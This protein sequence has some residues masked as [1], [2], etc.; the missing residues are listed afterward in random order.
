MLIKYKPKQTCCKFSNKGARHGSKD[1]IGYRAFLAF[2]CFYRIKIRP[3]LTEIWTE[4]LFFHPGSPPKKKQ[5]LPLLG[6]HLY[7]RIYGISAMQ[8]RL[9]LGD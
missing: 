2:R 9:L 5:G 6:R 7:W 8:Q 1:T 4:M 3:F